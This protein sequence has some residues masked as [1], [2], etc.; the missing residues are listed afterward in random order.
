MTESKPS[1]SPWS[2]R[3]ARLVEGRGKEFGPS[4]GRE[5]KDFE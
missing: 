4:G 2:M 3:S 5:D 1:H